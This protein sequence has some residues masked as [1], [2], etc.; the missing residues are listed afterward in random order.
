M[1]ERDRDR[2]DLRAAVDLD[3]HGLTGLVARERVPQLVGRADAPAADGDDHVAADHVA[4]AGDDDVRRPALEPGLRG[5]AA[6]CDALD[7]HALVDRQP[8]NAGE[9]GRDRAAGDAEVG[10]VDAAGRRQLRDDVLDRVRRDGEADADV[11]GRPVGAGDLRV[12]ADHLAARVQQR[13][14]RVAAVDLRVGLDH[15]VDRVA[16]RR[17]DRP[18]LD[19]AD[20]ACRRRP[21][22]P[23]RVADRDD[24]IADADVVGVAER[25]RCETAGARLHAQDGD[26]GGGIAADDRRAERVPVRE[27]DLDLVGPL[28]HVVVRDD[29]AGLVDHEARAERLL[30][31][32]LLLEGKRGGIV[33]RRGCRRDLDDSGRGA[34]VDLADGEPAVV[35]DRG[36]GGGSRG[37][38]HHGRRAAAQVA[39]H[40]HAAERDQPAEKGGGTERSGMRGS[41]TAHRIVVPRRS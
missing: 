16:V 28:D 35:G 7:Q 21:P 17:R 34:R 14:T 3:V 37:S 19:G 11:A 39:G 2:V 31:G 1:A 20:D 25:E 22:E 15:V 9:L 6:C 12:D 4:L 32:C 26:V 36:G 13:A 8:E 40:R 38:P 5:G 24:G 30:R 41:C 27:A 33:G 23:E 10:A 18:L 29:V